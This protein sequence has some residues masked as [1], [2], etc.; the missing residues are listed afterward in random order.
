MISTTA[1]YALRA[2]VFLARQAPDART[3]LEVAAATQVPAGYLS[4][5]LQLLVRAD[6][7]QSVFGKHGGYRLARRPADL[8]VLAIIN[9]VDP[10]R[11]VSVC[12]LRL[13]EHGSKLCPLH[14]RLDLATAL[15]E[16]A[17]AETTIRD[18]L[19]EFESGKNCDFPGKP[20]PDTQNRRPA[21]R[22]I[23]P[24]PTGIG[25]ARRVR[26]KRAR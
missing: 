18:L 2:V 10:I 13:N 6:V 3:T 19:L 15:V 17:F 9:S 1:E 7:L 5:V 8:T 20:A 26:A 25:R 4:K 14:R 16:Q 22:A 23:E 12:P 24:R 21:V 11:R